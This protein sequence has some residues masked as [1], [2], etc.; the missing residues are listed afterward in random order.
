M[1]AGQIR[2]LYESMPDRLTLSEKILAAH[3]HD[4]ETQE[5][6]LTSINPADYDRFEQNAASKRCR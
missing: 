6:A 5:W 4:F 1:S 3:C 2:A